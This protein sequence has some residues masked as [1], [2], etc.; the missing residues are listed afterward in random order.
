LYFPEIGWIKVNIDGATRCS[1]GFAACVGIFKGSREEYV[2][3][4]QLSWLFSID[5]MLKSWMSFLLLNML[6]QRVLKSF[7]WCLLCQAF[8]SSHII[9]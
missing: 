2:G 4:F 3:S 7:G 8:G 5:F 1:P 9:P 6:K